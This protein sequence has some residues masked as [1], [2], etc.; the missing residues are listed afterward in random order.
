[1]L[2]INLIEVSHWVTLVLTLPLL[3]LP[4]L[5]YIH[6]KSNQLSEG[7]LPIIMINAELKFCIILVFASLI[8]S[9]VALRIYFSGKTF[10]FPKFFIW[11]ISIFS[12]GILTSNLFAHSDKGL[13]IKYTLALSAIGFMHLPSSISMDKDKNYNLYQLFNPFWFSDIDNLPRSTLLMDGLE[14]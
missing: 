3:V 1:M 2:R 5:A 8:V 12:L 4:P 6:L 7:F 10:K 14:H 11:G 13:D 9:L